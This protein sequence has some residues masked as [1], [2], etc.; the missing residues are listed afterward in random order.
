MDCIQGVGEGGIKDDN[1]EHWLS[2]CGVLSAILSIPHVSSH[3]RLTTPPGCRGTVVPTYRLGN[4]LR[5]G[6]STC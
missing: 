2:T 6:L 3:R 4:R 5:E 1:S